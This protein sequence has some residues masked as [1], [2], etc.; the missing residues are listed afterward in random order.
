MNGRWKKSEDGIV[1][2]PEDDSQVFDIYVQSL[3]LGHVSQFNGQNADGLDY[4]M[5]AD[6]YA[7]AQKLQ[8]V[9]AKN[10]ASRAIYDKVY[11]SM[12]QRK[13]KPDKNFV[14]L[15]QQLWGVTTATSPIRPLLINACLIFRVHTEADTDLVTKNFSVMDA[16]IVLNVAIELMKR[17]HSDN[18]SLGPCEKY[19]ETMETEK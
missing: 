3:Y 11:A 7:I 5:L 15:A 16:E 18:Y 14:N 17:K 6:L 10:T 19:L 8:D 1:R 9:K 13:D 4:G 12:I 2:L